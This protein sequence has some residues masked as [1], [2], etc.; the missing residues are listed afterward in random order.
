MNYVM[1]FAA[2][3]NCFMKKETIANLSIANAHEIADKI[4]ARESRI[5]MSTVY[6]LNGIPQCFVSDVCGWETEK[7]AKDIRDEIISV[8]FTRLFD[9]IKG[10]EDFIAQSQANAYLTKACLTALFRNGVVVEGVEY[11]FLCSTASKSKQGSAY[12]VKVGFDKIKPIFTKEELEKIEAAGKFEAA[13]ISLQTVALGFTSCVASSKLLPEAITLD[14]MQMIPEVE[15]TSIVFDHAICTGRNSY[16]AIVA[17]ERTNVVRDMNWFDGASI[18]NRDLV[19]CEHNIQGR[20]CK[21][22]TTFVSFNAYEKLIGKKLPNLVNVDGEEFDVHN[23]KI[24]YNE[25]CC[26]LIKLAKVLD[27][28]HPW[29]YLKMCLKRAGWDQLYIHNVEDFQ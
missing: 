24:I 14:D 23:T 28:K 19:P 20:F 22:L 16:G 1:N 25:S 21:S 8:D 26:K 3:L 17:V 11:D 6:D 4:S 29:A 5:K 27:P 9:A 2:T 13:R 7:G 12:F 18:G 10:E 15:E